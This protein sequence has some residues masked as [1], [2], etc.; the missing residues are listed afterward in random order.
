MGVAAVRFMVSLKISLTVRDMTSNCAPSY[1]ICLPWP[2]SYNSF[3]VGKR[4]PSV[5]TQ[6]LLLGG[7]LKTTQ[8]QLSTMHIG[9]D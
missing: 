9:S 8:K 6:I 3:H 2:A 1:I 7:W 5:I 4:M